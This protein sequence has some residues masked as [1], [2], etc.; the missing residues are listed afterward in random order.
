MSFGGGTGPC[1]SLINARF[2]AV[3]ADTVGRPRVILKPD[4]E[5]KIEEPVGDPEEF[6]HDDSDAAI[7]PFSMIAAPSGLRSL[8]RRADEL[9]LS[10][11]FQPS[12]RGRQILTDVMLEDEEKEQ[13]LDGQGEL[14]IDPSDSDP[15]EI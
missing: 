6:D 2:A 5:A 8:S 12:L 3:K 4:S 9:G 7:I 11:R 13:R 14:R 10:S 1:S 15:R